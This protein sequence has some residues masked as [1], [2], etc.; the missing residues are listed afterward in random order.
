MPADKAGAGPVGANERT[1]M[2]S[3]TMVRSV[4]AATAAVLLLAGCGSASDDVAA[5][6]PAPTSESP[7]PEETA[8]PEETS[9]ADEAGARWGDGV[10]PEGYSFGPPNGL[11]LQEKDVDAAETGAMLGP[12]AAYR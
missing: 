4:G 1:H 10:W 5:P 3:R 2:R 11:P 8:Q 12:A 9:S 6:E 7:S